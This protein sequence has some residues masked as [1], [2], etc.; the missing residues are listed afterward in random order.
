M[1]FS[2]RRTAAAVTSALLATTLSAGALSLAAAVVG[3]A[4]HAGASTAPPW[5]PDPDSVGGL[6]FYNASGDVVTGGNLT[7]DPPAA[8]VEGTQT[9]SSKDDRATLYG[10]LPVPEEPTGDWSGEALTASTLY[11]NTSAPAPLNTTTL[12]VVTGSA[13]DESIGGLAS[14]YP[15]TSTVSGYV[16]M[17]Q[18]RLY[19]S[20]S[21]TSQDTYDSADIEIDPT[22][23]TWQVVYSA[24]LATSTTTSLA[25]SP[26]KSATYGSAVTLTATVSPSGAAGSVDFLAGTKVVGK[27]TVSDGKA[28]LKT[29]A[30]PGGADKLTARFTGSSAAWGS[31][32][33]SLVDYT[34]KAATTK[35]A[36][37]ASTTSTTSGASVTLTATLSPTAAT[38]T[39][40]FYS[41]KSK[42]GSKSVT[43]GTATF[44]TKK[45][46]V[47]SDSI[48]A[49]FTPSV[50]AD[51]AGSTSKAVTVKVAK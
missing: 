29:A 2:L 7:D 6:V 38:G 8:Y 40:A 21:G 4:T 22:A 14:D 3:P 26:S 18:L 44:S 20:A 24:P 41:G 27:A 13:L 12:P 15:N 25:V 31:S 33:S 51:Y 46:A 42:L 37:K 43:K 49:V 34:V 11:P 19:S 47:G 28:V 50:K 35:T 5:E 23:G 36:L 1:T 45:L 17:Y 48:T 9:I 32:T 16:D 10:F 30:L 39:V